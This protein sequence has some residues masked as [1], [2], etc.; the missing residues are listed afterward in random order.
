MRASAARPC[1]RRSARV[2]AA[3]RR[4]GGRSERSGSR[5]ERSFGRVVKPEG[6]LSRTVACRP[7]ARQAWPTALDFRDMD[8]HLGRPARGP[9]PSHRP[10]PEPSIPCPSPR[11]S[12]IRRACCTRWAPATPSVPSAWHRSTTT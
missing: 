10:A 7:R 8:G 3:R 1:P 2:A 11:T 12:P 9:K 6:R 4:G 5:S